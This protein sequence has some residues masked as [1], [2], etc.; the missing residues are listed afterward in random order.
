MTPERNPWNDDDR[1]APR[2]GGGG[3]GLWLWA[4]LVAGI[5][6]LVWLLI[7]L[8]PQRDLASGDWAQLVKLG[9]ILAVCASGLLFVRR[10]PIGETLRSL[11]IWVGIGALLLI[12]YSFRDDFS[13]L[14]NRIAGELMP[15]QA[16]EVGEGVVEIRTG[17]GG[18]FTVTA[19]V[20]GVAVDFLVDTGA[21]DIVLSPADAERVGF[22]PAAL[23]FTRQYS[24]ANGIGRGAPVRLDDIAIGPIYFDRVPASV[25][26]APMSNSLLG[27]TFLRQLDSYEVRGDVL[28][29]RR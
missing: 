17:I 8:F 5:M 20:N 2:G 10:I 18:H 9:A 14:G 13:G 15:S 29:L 27:M 12:G 4:L 28:I 23:S 7:S 26:E 24:T 21:S 19:E 6:G 22:D 3:P 1:D 11:A 25:N 16:V